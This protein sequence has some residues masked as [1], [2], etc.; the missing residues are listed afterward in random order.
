ME[1]KTV[2]KQTI[3]FIH[4]SF[5]EY[6]KTM[7]LDVRFLPILYDF[8]QNEK[9]N[10]NDETCEL[11][12]PY[13]TLDNFN[14]AVA[15]KASNAAEGLCKWV[16]AMK[17]YHEAAKIVKPKLDLLNVQTK[18]LEVAMGELAEA[19][20]ELKKAE[21]ALNEINASFEAAM[22]VKNTIEQR[23]MATKRRMDK[24]NKLINGLAG[25]K[26]R[27]TEDSNTF[28]ERRMRL[29]GDVAAAAAFVSY[30]GPFNSE[31]RDKI[32]KECIMETAVKLAVPV[33]EHVHVTSFLAD[34]GTIGE[35]NL[36]GLPTD[37]LSVQNGLIVTSAS[38]FPLMI[39]P[40]GQALPWIKRREEQRMEGFSQCLT[41][42][43]NP[44]F[45]DQ[46]EF[47]LGE[48]LPFLI[49][50]V[51]DAL[52]PLL[53]PVL[54]KQVIKKG[55]NLY[56]PLSDQ[57][58]DYNPSFKLYMTSRLANPHFSPELSAK[59]AVIDFTVTQKGLEEQL[60][61]RVLSMEQKSLEQSLT[62][63]IEEVTQNTKSLQL[64]DSQLLERLSHSEGNLLDDVELIEV[65]ANTKAKAKEV[66]QKLS[67][68]A[69]KK[70]EINEKRE[71][72]RP[73]ASRG[74]VLY[75]CIVEMS[76]VSWM[77]NS[78]LSQFLDQF[79]FSIHRSE[80][81]QPMSKRVDKIVEFLTYQMYRYVNR[82]L[83]E[84]HRRTFVVMVALKIL[85][86]ANTLSGA[87]VAILLKA[88]DGLDEKAEAAPPFKTVFQ[89]A[90]AWLN[91]LAL[92]RHQFGRERAS[93]YKDLPDVIARTEPQWKKWVEDN[94]PE[95]LP[96]P[97]YEERLC[98][99]Y[100][101]GPFLRF[102]L[103]RALRDDRTLIAS[104]LFIDRQMGATYT[105]PVTDSVEAIRKESSARVPVLFL[106]SPGSDPTSTIDELA[107]KLKKFPVD[108][109][110]MGEGQ[111]VI[112]K[113][114]LKTGFVAGNW[115]VL[116]N[117]HLGLGF[118]GE[119][120]GIL[121]SAAD[122]DSE[123]RLWITC[124]P[125]DKF[126]IGL[127]QMSIKVTNEPPMG[128][129]AGL[130]RT[131][132]TT[133]TQEM[134]DRTDHEKWRMVVFAT[135]FLHSIVQERRKFGPIGWCIPYE[136]NC[137]DLDASLLFLERHMSNT[138]MVG[139]PMSWPTVSYMIAEV[140]Y[141]GRL[142]DDLDRELFNCYASKWLC[143]DI[144]KLDFSFSQT[145]RE[146]KV[147]APNE[148]P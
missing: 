13:L 106:L 136:F 66:E 54:E 48:G 80:K 122:I 30:C 6:A 128:L 75:F 105:D 132:T 93:F 112:A 36:E 147:A 85:V 23:A 96:V 35:W 41:T 63:L 70:T 94:E 107:K 123:F 10:V 12:E 68:A 103:I 113:E 78:S 117:C 81:A 47:C 27:W 76:L 141:G 100:E 95:T 119:I 109:V 56:I 145:M 137:S 74:S 49:E 19:E 126:P 121:N 90:S 130:Y 26:Q 99:D 40:Q 139:A 88:G 34:Q 91:I 67:D 4:D 8:S 44:R 53:D 97:Y 29:V 22:T 42:L 89:D 148:F 92:S 50:G 110:S 77:Y 86:Q 129:K 28:A 46:L 31:Y 18:R 52:D 138:I 64:L 102:C 71:Q 125:H 83:F 43:L 2:N 3:H 69:S 135:S 55:R 5:D 144:F 127:L 17:M 65:L 7:I 62:H 118:M 32:F 14:P 24:A 39:D 20:A 1:S 131:Y 143:D 58:A 87:D 9:D 142:T 124:E 84:R 134:L 73:V 140:Q 115:V 79:D 133:V 57:L 38:R 45:K 33:S 72:Y 51:E 116:Q 37:E 61:G 114:K 104:A 60:L 101:L 82:G 21:E 120:E 98:A 111:E 15:K 25:E 16:G 146:G 108:K 11:L 59:C